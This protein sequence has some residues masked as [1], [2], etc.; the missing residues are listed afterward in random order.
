MLLAQISLVVLKNWV[1]LNYKLIIQVS[2]LTSWLLTG[3]IMLGTTFLAIVIALTELGV[4]NELIND[5]RFAVQ[6]Q[7]SKLLLLLLIMVS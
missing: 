1:G 2:L 3:W 5:Y 6:S 7:T 4:L